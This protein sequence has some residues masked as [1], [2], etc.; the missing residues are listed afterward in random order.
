MWVLMRVLSTGLI[1]PASVRVPLPAGAGAVVGY[2]HGA[3]AVL[4]ADSGGP[5]IER[6]SKGGM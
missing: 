4:C 1:V 3:S 2:Q 5:Q 6:V